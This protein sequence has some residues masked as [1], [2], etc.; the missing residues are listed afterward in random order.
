MDSPV[1]KSQILILKGV[2]FSDLDEIVLIPFVS[3]TK[4][5]DE[6]PTRFTSVEKWPKSTNLK[7]WICDR[8]FGSYPKFIPTC[9][10]KVFKN[11]KY[12]EECV[13]YGNFCEWD[14]AAAHTDAFIAPDQRADTH[15]LLRRYEEK[16]TGV[17]KLKIPAAISKTE[18]KK[19]CG[20][21]GLTDEQFD[22]KY[23]VHSS[24][25]TITNCQID[26]Y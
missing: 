25:Y 12:D 7:C 19:Y 16:F 8:R 15:E 6:I 24:N 9:P 3:D 21:R 5:Y 22:A 14:C 10:E 17:R 11:G 18:M 2:F 1:K 26:T 20:P 4:N 23:K 13:P